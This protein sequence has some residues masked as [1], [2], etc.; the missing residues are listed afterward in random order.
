MRYKGQNPAEYYGDPGERR[1][2]NAKT[3]ASAVAAIL[4]QLPGTFRKSDIAQKLQLATVRE[5]ALL[6]DALFALQTRALIKWNPRLSAW[7]NYTL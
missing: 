1:Y 4:D 5:H 3:L 7:D 2:T 6:T